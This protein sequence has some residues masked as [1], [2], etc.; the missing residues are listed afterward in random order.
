MTFEKGLPVTR[1]PGHGI[2]V[3]SIYS[4]AERYNGMYSF[5]EKDGRF[6][7]RVSL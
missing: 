6:V 3:R 7:L 1:E 4:I 5:S 2:G